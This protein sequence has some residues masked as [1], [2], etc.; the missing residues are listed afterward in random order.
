LVR[1]PR[2]IRAGWREAESAPSSAIEAVRRYAFELEWQR[3]GAYSGS[4]ACHDYRW[5]IAL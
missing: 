2:A 3:F 4:A 5:F 1:F